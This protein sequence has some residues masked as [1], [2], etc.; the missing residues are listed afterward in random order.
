MVVFAAFKNDKCDPFIPSYTCRLLQQGT[1][2]HGINAGTKLIKLLSWRLYHLFSVIRATYSVVYNDRKTCQRCHNAVS[3]S[4]IIYGT[5]EH[6][7]TFDFKHQI[8][9]LELNSVTGT[10]WQLHPFSTKGGIIFYQELLTLVLQHPCIKK[11]L[12]R[13]M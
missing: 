6:T 11:T 13:I 3:M 2:Q 7:N 9:T 1:R 8:V 4:V 5:W 10:K 12:L